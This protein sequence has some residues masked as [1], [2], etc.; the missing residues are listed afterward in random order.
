ML[1]E[2]IEDLQ[3]ENKLQ[4]HQ[5]HE[6]EQWEP[7]AYTTKMIIDQLQSDKHELAEDNANIKNEI[8]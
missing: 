3:R 7:G 1:K 4:Q 2:K 8:T 6:D 5:I